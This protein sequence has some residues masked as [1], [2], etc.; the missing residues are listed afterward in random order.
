M[1]L[2]RTGVSPWIRGIAAGLLLLAS[3]VEPVAQAQCGSAPLTIQ[4]QTTGNYTNACT[5]NPVT[6]R[7]D[8]TVTLSGAV[9]SNSTVTIRGANTLQLGKVTVQN[10]TAIDTRVNI[11][12]SGF[13]QRIGGLGYF[14]KGTS[15]TNKVLLLQLMTA[16]DVGYDK[17]ANAAIRADM[18]YNLSIG[19]NVLGDL[20]SEASGRTMGN[21]F[22]QGDLR[23]GISLGSL[24]SLHSLTVGGNFGMPGQPPVQVSISGN[25]L[26]LAAGA[27]NADITTLA[28]GSAGTVHAFDVTAGSFAGSLRVHRLGAMPDGAG[29]AMFRIAGDLDAS[30]TI[31]RDIR[32]PFTVGGMFKPTR[33][34]AGS[35]VSNVISATTGLFDDPAA[36]PTSTVIVQ[37]D[38]AG[39]MVL[40]VP[41][42][43]GLSSINRAVI[44]NGR[45]TGSITTAQD[46]DASIT[47]NGPMSG[48]IQIDGSLKSGRM[49]Q[50]NGV[51]GG[52]ISIGSS[53][54]GT[55]SVPGSGLVGQV[56][57]NAAN[58]GGVWAGQVLVGGVNPFSP[59]PSYTT[60][61]S[62]V[63]GGAVGVAPFRLD[64][65]DCAPAHNN[66]GPGGFANSSLFTNTSNAPVL[67]RFYGPVQPSPG[68][69]LAQAVAVEQQVGPNWVDRSA[70]FT[71]AFLPAGSNG[72]VIAFAPSGAGSPPVGQY[73]VRP[74][75]L[76][77]T[78]VAGTPNVLWSSAYQFRVDTDCNGDGFGDAAQI[79]ANPALDADQDGQ[80]DECQG[81]PSC[82]CDFNNTGTVTVQ[83]VFDYL[84][85][86]F[87]A[88][89]LADFNLSGTVTI[90]DIFDFLGCYFARPA[91]C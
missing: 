78:G 15:G 9:T 1:R 74:I 76:Q 77:S 80:L 45:L 54:L 16:G 7:W 24:S 82:P 30:L 11:L 29:P 6:N 8:V 63:G 53:L 26:N 66:P 14:D 5:L 34:V 72:R 22:I 81:G 64:L 50:C 25:I 42:A 35:P 51:M 79:A 10:N 23:G 52:T 13:D 37:G 60:A 12:G 75:A 56:V 73:R 40:G 48:R 83:D 18:I 67:M 47:V 86:Y 46:V 61:S 17:P 3:P 71:P 38:F 32:V 87:T 55:I 65:D 44:I 90:Q 91:G 59:I 84:G 20:V 2:I 39:G 89:P 21:V 28:N 4:V 43:A 70:Y 33:V 69:S 88:S 62:A 68:F 49:V 58:G 27:I 31:T 57:I 41:L 19:G 85:A 36:D